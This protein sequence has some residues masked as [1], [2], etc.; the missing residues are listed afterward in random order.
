DGRGGHPVQNEESGSRVWVDFSSDDGHGGGGYGPRGERDG[1]VG[2]DIKG[3]GDSH[4]SWVLCVP[5]A[6]PGGSVLGILCL[7][8][9]LAASATLAPAPAPAPAPPPVPAYARD[10]AVAMP[11]APSTAAP[12]DACLR[13]AQV[14][15]SCSGLA[16]G[17]CRA[18]D[19][20]GGKARVALG[21]ALAEGRLQGRHE[22]DRWH[23]G[24]AEEAEEKHA[25]G[26]ADLVERR[27]AMV[28]AVLG[29]AAWR[30][31]AGALLWGLGAW[32]E[33][34]RLLRR[35]E[36]AGRRMEGLRLRRALQVWW[37]FA[38]AQSRGPA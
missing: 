8:L 4:V 19:E 35:E 29:A 37:C 33:G 6:G 12:P 14:L 25:R 7:S 36:S 24:E 17:W 20:A 2:D 23:A 9:S 10:P 22:S 31:V 18:L 34:V 13:A 11:P 1:G 28:R 16:L 27:R 30:R 26:V 3:D 21:V 15:A 38:S 32:R 5:V